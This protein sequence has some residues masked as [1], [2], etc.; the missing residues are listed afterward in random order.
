MNSNSQKHN[1]HNH[2]DTMDFAC[3]FFKSRGGVVEIRGDTRDILL[4]PETAKALEV[5]EFFRVGPEDVIQAGTGSSNIHAVQL[6]TPFLDRMLSLAGG[7]SPFARAELKFDY[8]KT[9]GFERLL[10]DQFVFHRSKIRITKTGQAR[11]RYLMLTC[12]YTAQSDEVKQGLV[13]ICVNL[14]TGV[15]IP[16]MAQALN[17]TQK[18]FSARNGGGCT[19]KE[20]DHIQTIVSRYGQQLV[21]ARLTS[22]IESMNR[23]FRR[24]TASLDEYYGAL[25]KEMKDSLNRSGLSENLLKDRQE[26][27]DMIPAELAAKKKDLLNKYSI[28]ID[29]KPAAALYLTSPCVTVFAKLISGRNNANLTLTYNPVTKQMDPA[30][31][32]S[33][34]SGTY[35]I[36]CC[37]NLHIICPDCLDQGCRLC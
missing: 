3:R 7:S 9:Q 1:A 2:I 24:D 15:V 21:E 12:R 32:K 8:V 10:T 18:D 36:G 14:D 27:I 31:C 26:K 37:Q 30:A 20:I 22:F 17:N 5:E 4:P 13:D 11:T 16:E 23:R 25:E 34:G 19:E 33:C 29:F 28:H 6:H 35:G